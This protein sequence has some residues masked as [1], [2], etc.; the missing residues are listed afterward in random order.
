METKEKCQTC[1]TKEKTTGMFCHSCGKL[2]FICVK[3]Y[4]KK[5]PIFLICNECKELSKMNGG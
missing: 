5:E 2:I 3:C 4:M 1:G